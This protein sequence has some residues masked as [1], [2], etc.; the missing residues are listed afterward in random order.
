[1]KGEVAGAE[2]EGRLLR[3]VRQRGL[4]EVA[5]EG[6]FELAHPAAGPDPVEGQ[7]GQHRPG[8]DVVAGES[9]EG[10]D[11]LGAEIDPAAPVGEAFRRPAAAGHEAGGQP[12]GH[13][14]AAGDR[15]EQPDL[16]QPAGIVQPQQR[17]QVEQRRAVAA[18]GQAQRGALAAGAGGF[19][20]RMRALPLGARLLELD[21]DGL[22]GR[23]RWRGTARLYKKRPRITV[24]FPAEILVERRR[25]DLPTMAWRSRRSPSGAAAPRIPLWRAA[26]YGG[27]GRRQAVRAAVPAPARAR[28]GA[29]PTGPRA[30]RPFP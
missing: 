4:A 28:R 30:I 16:L 20:G 22:H 6:V 27:A 2:H 9:A 7:G 25:I 24:A 8:A 15:T 12:G 11:H 23:E 14:A 1:A 29:S 10:L 21:V 19:L 3:Q 17:A 26:L 13:D 18:T 5:R